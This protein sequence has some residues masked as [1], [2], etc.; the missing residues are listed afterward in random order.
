[1][2][3]YFVILKIIYLLLHLNLLI[4]NIRTKRSIF[5]NI[6]FSGQNRIRSRNHQIH[7]IPP[8]TIT[9]GLLVKQNPNVRAR[10]GEI[11]GMDIAKR[12]WEILFIPLSLIEP[13]AGWG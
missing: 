1:M 9:I 13:I 12:V 7:K 4:I 6:R 2:M 3:L 8:I 11:W 5:N 10:I